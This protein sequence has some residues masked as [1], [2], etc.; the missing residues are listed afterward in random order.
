LPIIF[1]E[2]IDNQLEIIIIITII[3][4]IITIIITGI[5]IITIIII[6]TIIIGTIRKNNKLNY[7]V[8]AYQLH[9]YKDYIPIIILDHNSNAPS[10]SLIS[11]ST[12]K[13]HSYTAFIAIILTVFKP[14]SKKIPNALSVMKMLEKI[15]EQSK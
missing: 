3:T 1:P 13:P 15:Y 8:T 9:N 10:A 12:T 5:I 11:K 14:G 7:H 6:K 2:I 4:I